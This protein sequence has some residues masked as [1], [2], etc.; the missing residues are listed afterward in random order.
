MWADRQ[1]QCCPFGDGLWIYR[2]THSVH[3]WLFSV[4]SLFFLFCFSSVL[5]YYWRCCAAIS[6]FCLWFAIFCFSLQSLIYCVGGKNV[7]TIPGWMCCRLG[8]GQSTSSFPRAWIFERI[9]FFCV[10]VAMDD[11]VHIPQS[12]DW[13][14]FF[15]FKF[16]CP[17]S[18]FVWFCTLPPSE[19]EPCSYSILYVE[20]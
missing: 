12:I 2:P 11:V 1:N 3:V 5:H 9:S 7:G 16:P 19:L 20:S 15:F 4:L 14:F 8:A 13:I 17:L 10:C 18:F 6:Y